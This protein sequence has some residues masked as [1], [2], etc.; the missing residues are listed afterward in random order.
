[1]NDEIKLA[2]QHYNETEK[3][4]KDKER[5]IQD[6]ES[7]VNDAVKL[8]SDAIRSSI[9]QNFGLSTEQTFGV[10]D[11]LTEQFIESIRNGILDLPVV[12]EK[13]EKENR[14]LTEARDAERKALSNFQLANAPRN[15]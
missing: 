9:G 6:M 7:W 3:S 4:R 12:K 14:K 5:L 2:I 10:S 13:F 15:D 11:D 8:A 1:M